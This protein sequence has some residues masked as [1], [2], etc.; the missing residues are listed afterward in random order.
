MITKKIFCHVNKSWFVKLKNRRIK[1]CRTDKHQFTDCRS[2]RGFAHLF[3][4]QIS[5]QNFRTTPYSNFQYCFNNSWFFFVCYLIN[6]LFYLL[7][8]CEV[9]VRISTKIW[10]VNPTPFNNSKIWWFFFWWFVVAWLT[11][12][13]INC[14]FQSLMIMFISHVLYSS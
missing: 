2:R 3:N 8:N 1:F 9:N 5:I 4:L 12:F 14:L 10:S 13:S 11:L 6:S 7:I